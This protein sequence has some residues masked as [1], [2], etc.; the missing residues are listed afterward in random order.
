MLGDNKHGIECLRKLNGNIKIIIGNHDTS[1]RIKLYETL[2]NVEIIGYAT[3]LK[4]NKYHF[5]LSHYPTL[6]SNLE[7]SPNL[8]LHVINLY[9]HTHQ[10]EDFYQEIPYMFH[11]GMDSNNCTPV[12]LDDAIE[13]MKE[14]TQKCLEFLDEE[15]ITA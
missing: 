14:E 10:E 9:G 12:L 1:A 2:E 15:N 6:T 13:K 7:K 8:K 5:Y 3:V 4:Y 11:C